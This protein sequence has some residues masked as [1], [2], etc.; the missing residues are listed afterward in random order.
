MV[1]FDCGSIE[2]AFNFMGIDRLYKNKVAE[3]EMALDSV[4]HRGLFPDEFGLD[5]RR[6][7]RA[8]LQVSS[9][10]SNQSVLDYDFWLGIF[11]SDRIFSVDHHD[12]CSNWRD[13]FS[14]EAKKTGGSKAGQN[15][16]R[17]L[18]GQSS[19]DARSTSFRKR[20]F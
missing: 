16:I 13:Y 15:R 2:S 7:L 1:L 11:T 10:I 8:D 18:P 3:T 6:N 4:Y 17:T 5:E 19:L 20:C 9:Y 14:A 12:I